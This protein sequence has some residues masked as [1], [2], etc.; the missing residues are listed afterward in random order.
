MAKSFL[1]LGGNQGNRTE[2]IQQAELFITQLTG[3]IVQKSLIYE[4][5][6][7]G[8]KAENNFLNSVVEIETNLSPEK[9]LE[10]V[11]GIED[12]LGRK[13]SGEGYSSRTM[14]IDILFYDNLIIKTPTLTI[15]HPRLHLRKFTLL[16]LA[17]IAP[18]YTH[19]ELHKT[20][21]LLRL[22]CQDNSKVKIYNQEV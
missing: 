4:S 15:P 17:E 8:F 13:R 22:E 1:L 19:P 6:A 11:L 10:T 5:E 16:P 18:N 14:D 20:L 2:L 21:E 9:L 3:T 12:K 7:W